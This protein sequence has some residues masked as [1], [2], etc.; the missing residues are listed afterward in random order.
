MLPSNNPDIRTGSS[1]ACSRLEAVCK[2][3]C[4]LVAYVFHAR[5]THPYYKQGTE[6]PAEADQGGG[7]VES[8]A[9]PQLDP[10]QRQR[11]ADAAAAVTALQAHRQHAL[12]VLDA[13]EAVLLEEGPAGGCDQG[14]LCAPLSRTARGDAWTHCGDWGPRLATALLRWWTGSSPLTTTAADACTDARARAH[15]RTLEIA[16]LCP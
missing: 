7:E 13:L 16:G 6:Q 1:K 2:H 10:E 8:S 4:A 15:T 3:V 11:L 14:L 12:G 5:L 9:Q